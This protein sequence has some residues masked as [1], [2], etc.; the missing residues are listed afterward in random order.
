MNLNL[1]CLWKMRTH[2]HSS[3]R[4]LW[5]KADNVM[6]SWHRIEKSRNS[7]L[8]LGF[9]NDS[10][11]NLNHF[12]SC[13]SLKWEQWSLLTTVWKCMWATQI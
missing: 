2:G 13:L 11:V 10:F 3:Q 7:C 5:W 9:V 12:A 6:K 8:W 4:Q 1:N